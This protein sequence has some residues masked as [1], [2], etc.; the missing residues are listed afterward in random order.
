MFITKMLTLQN[1]LRIFHWQTKSYA[2]H[3]A[4][5]SAYDALDD[6]IDSFVETYFGKNGIR[7]ATETFNISLANYGETD[8][9][10]VLDD[11]VNFLV[12]ELPP[13]LETTDTELLNIRDDM[14]ATIN[15]TKYL[16]TL[17]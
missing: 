1:Q 5:G 14:L 7:K 2:E 15:H 10:G 16:L 8:T 11:A 13:M 3:K 12:N 9:V 6:S 4:L 17:K